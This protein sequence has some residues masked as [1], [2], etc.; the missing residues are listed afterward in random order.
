MAD[1]LPDG[2]ELRGRAPALEPGRAERG[3]GARARRRRRGARRRLR[4]ARASAA[5]AAER[6]RAIPVVSVDAR[7]TT[8]AA[9][10]RVA[11]T[12]AAAG[13]HRAGVVHRLDGVPVP[14]RALLASSRPSDE[15][16]LAAIARRLA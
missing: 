4:S 11:F 10:A 5:A 6:L 16:V 3:G 14:L 2:R 1:R 12:T 15:E 9:A 8:T 13:V 7:D